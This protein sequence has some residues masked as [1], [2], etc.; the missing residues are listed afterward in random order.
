LE[1]LN[2]EFFK[3]MYLFE[4][5]RKRERERALKSTGWGGEEGERIPSGLHVECGA[6]GQA[7]SHDPEIA[8]GVEIKSLVA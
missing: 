4:R 2:Y 1:I 6:L 3:K 5:E 7:P 8:T